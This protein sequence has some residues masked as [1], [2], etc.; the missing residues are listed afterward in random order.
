MT[1]TQDIYSVDWSTMINKQSYY[2]AVPNPSYKNILKNGLGITYPDFF[3]WKVPIL[4]LVGWTNPADMWAQVARPIS[5]AGLIQRPI[6]SFATVYFFRPGKGL[7]QAEDLIGPIS[8]KNLVSTQIAAQV[9]K[10][11]QILCKWCMKKMR[12]GEPALCC[13]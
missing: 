8:S 5:R 6:R 12:V 1:D 7:A 10:L 13:A 2:V 4:N 9:R 11:Q 3:F